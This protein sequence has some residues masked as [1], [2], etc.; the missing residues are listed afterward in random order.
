MQDQNTEFKPTT[1]AIKNKTSIYLATLFITLIGISTYLSLPK[2]NFPE[3]VIPNI[4]VATVY[5]G[6]APTDMENVVT[7]V[8]E[9]EIKAISGVKKITSNSMQDF[10]TI[11]VEFNT[12]IK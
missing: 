7:K 5:A 1:W 4:F 8:L 10:S 6:A 11:I 12:G 3:V 9:K 2:E